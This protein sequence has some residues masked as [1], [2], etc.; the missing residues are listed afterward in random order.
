VK[1]IQLDDQKMDKDFLEGLPVTC[2]AI[3]PL[4]EHL[5]GVLN[6]GQRIVVLLSNRKKYM[7]EVIGF[8][9]QVTDNYAEGKVELI[10]YIKG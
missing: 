5:S 4:K 8:S 7:A 2:D 3:V 10:R 1:S 9:N 6:H